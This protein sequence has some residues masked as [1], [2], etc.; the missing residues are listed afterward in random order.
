MSLTW[1]EEKNQR[2]KARAF[3]VKEQ[4]CSTVM[5]PEFSEAVFGGDFCGID[6]NRAW[7]LKQEQAKHPDMGPNL[8]TDLVNKMVLYV[9]PREVQV[10]IQNLP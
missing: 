10:I 6:P 2:E 1:I 7:L 3:L 4:R 5:T 8:L 9:N